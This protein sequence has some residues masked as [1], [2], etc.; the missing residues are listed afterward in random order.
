MRPAP[1][2]FGPRLLEP[3]LDSIPH[4]DDT[5]KRSAD[6]LPTLPADV[7]QREA[8]KPKVEIE[9]ESKSPEA[10]G[11]M[12]YTMVP[13]LKNVTTGGMPS[14]EG[15][16]W[17]KANKVRYV[18]FLHRA[19]YDT[20]PAKQLCEARNMVFVSIPME[21]ASVAQVRTDMTVAVAFAELGP[22]YVC[23]DAKFQRAGMA[24]YAYFRR[25]LLISPDASAI[26]VKTLGFD[27][28]A[29]PQE[30]KSLWDAVLAELK[31]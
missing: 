14:L 26:R 13:G 21:A 24:W 30:Y 1:G 9:R 31:Q 2:N 15:L 3:I 20:A 6:A 18:V 7:P 16:D 10:L 28:E 22:V 11:L 8:R 27:P 23:D 19:D 17:L 5:L 12:G 4:D 25:T 29:I